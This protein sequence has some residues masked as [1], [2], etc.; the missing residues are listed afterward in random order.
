MSEVSRTRQVKPVSIS[1]ILPAS[2]TAADKPP[3]C[4][5]VDPREL[6]VEEK[7]QR[8]LG[9]NSTKLIRGIVRDFSWAKFKPPTCAE[10]EGG[11][12]FVI[13]GQHTAIASASHPKVEK[14]PVMVVE[15]VTVKERAEAFIG[16]NRDRLNVTPMQMYYS[17]V[18]AGDPVALAMKAGMDQAG[19][20]M[21]RFQ[22]PAWEIGDTVA[23][24]TIKTLADKRGASAVGRVLN[25]LMNARRGPLIAGEIK[26]VAALCFDKDWK[27][28]FDDRALAK[29]IASKTCDQWES[30]AESKVRKGMTMSL[31][32][33]LAILWFRQVPK[34][35][36]SALKLVKD[37]KT[38]AA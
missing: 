3:E 30:E 13:D 33:A 14:I 35:K 12:L 5:W 19:V 24:G 37:G 28:K 21:K 29:L 23:A 1:G 32:R 18:A 7:Y 15:A 8:M 27:D 17:G 4:R 10:G 26:A 36:R 9:A 34:Q 20:T 38:E 31:H 25:V 16:H 2:L 22:P 11:K 6:H